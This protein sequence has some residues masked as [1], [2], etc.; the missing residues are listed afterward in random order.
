MAGILSLA[1]EDFCGRVAV[2]VFNPAGNGRVR[3]TYFL[4]SG[5]TVVMLI[6]FF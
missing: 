6:T 5:F 2:A 1:S 4:C 3:N